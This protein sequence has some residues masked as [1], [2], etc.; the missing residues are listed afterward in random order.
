MI[1]NLDLLECVSDKLLRLL[2]D[3]LEETTTSVYSSGVNA[4]TDTSLQLKL[5]S[6]V[7]EMLNSIWQKVSSLLYQMI[8]IDVD[9]RS[10]VS[11]ATTPIT[12]LI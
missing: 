1:N 7:K 5:A 8:K 9:A 6:Y 11:A 2:H 12:H 4:D 10:S 3:V